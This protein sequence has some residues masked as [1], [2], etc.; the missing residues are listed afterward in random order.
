MFINPRLI[1]SVLKDLYRN[2]NFYTVETELSE[3]RVGLHPQKQISNP[4][5]TIE[6]YSLSEEKRTE[7]EHLWKGLIEVKPTDRYNVVLEYFLDG[8][9]RTTLLGEIPFRHGSPHTCALH[10][11]QYACVVLKRDQRQLRRHRTEIRNLLELPIAF[12][13]SK[14]NEGKLKRYFEERVRLPR[15]ENVEWVD[16]SFG[17]ERCAPDDPRKK[18]V[19]DGVNYPRLSDEDLMARCADPLWFRG[20]ARHWTTRF[21]DRT[22]YKLSQEMADTIGPARRSQTEFCFAVK[23]GGIASVRRGL[24]KAI[25]G[26]VKSFETQFLNEYEH[27]RVMTLGK[28]Y[29]TPAF[30]FQPKADSV[31][32]E[33]IHGGGGK[34]PN[35][36]SWY[37]RLHDRRYHPP[38]FGLVRIEVHPSTLPSQGRQDS[39]SAEDSVL[40]NAISWAVLCERLPLSTPDP[41]WDR[42]IYPIKV[43]ERYLQSILLPQSTV[44]HFGQRLS[45]EL[46]Q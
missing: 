42:L 20:H 39:W 11:A 29:R 32:P 22:E 33:E 15:V 41:R 1:A 34:P 12:L 37:L 19:I 25:L 10:F 43:C 24:E 30:V 46:E 45:T 14:A 18:V 27:V 44:K 28:G 17:S 8:V 26:I 7:P 38:E 21:R 40:L 5:R 16:T 2:S 35:R 13:Q 31:E 23:D 6:T 4:G 36:V 9:Q 3:E